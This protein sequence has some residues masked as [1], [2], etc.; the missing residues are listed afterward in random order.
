[1]TLLHENEMRGFLSTLPMGLA[2]RKR[3]LAILEQYFTVVVFP[4]FPKEMG[5]QYAENLNTL[6]ALDNVEAI[7]QP[8]FK[9]GWVSVMEK[10]HY[11]N[12]QPWSLCGKALLSAN[13]IVVTEPTGGKKCSTCEQRAKEKVEN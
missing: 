2:S 1:M 9:T 8:V 3:R 13:K 6:F 7:E 10:W 5:H 4:E 11:F 12:D